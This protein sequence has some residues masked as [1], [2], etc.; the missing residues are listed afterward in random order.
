MNHLL[1]QANLRDQIYCDSAATSDYHIG[2][3]PDR[4]MTQ[5]AHHQG[6][7]LEGR[8]RQ[9]Q[10]ADFENFDLILAMDRQNYFNILALDLNQQYQS[11]VRL[12]CDFC[13]RHRDQEVPDP[14]YGEAD[15]FE[16]VID[17]LTDA[18]ESLLLYLT[19]AEPAAG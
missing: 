2:K 19:A 4:R 13:T 10:P 11:K 14:Y 17:L 1:E 12:I 8:G 6:I 5:A 15:G 3:P 9:F 7:T 18:C 16:Y